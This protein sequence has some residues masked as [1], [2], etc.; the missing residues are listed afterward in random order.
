MHLVG[1][2]DEVDVLLEHATGRRTLLVICQCGRTGASLICIS[3][4]SFLVPRSIVYRHGSGYSSFGHCIYARINET[5]NPTA[6]EE[7]FVGW[8]LIECFR[9]NY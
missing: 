3:L 4:A 6:R 9:V 7:S 8:R 5:D 2:Y 1:F